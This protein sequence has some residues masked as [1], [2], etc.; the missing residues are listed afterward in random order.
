MV[1]ARWQATITDDAGNVQDAA[2]VEVRAE[3]GGA[4]LAT[5]Y[6]DRDG[7]TPISNPLT[8]GSDG[9][10]A[11]H[12]AGGAYKI[13]ASKG[14]F[15]REWRY[16]PIG[17]AAEQDSA[18]VGIS[19]IFD[20][21][22]T[23]A[24]PGAGF[25]RFNNATPGSATAL[26][27]DNVDA[28]GLTETTWL[29]SIDDG[30]SSSDRGILVMRSANGG[31]LVVARVT[32]SVVDGTG[33][34]KVTISV[35]AASDASAF[36]SGA[37]FSLIF[38]RAGIDGADGEVTSTGTFAA[39]DLAA[40]TDTGGDE[41]KSSGLSAATAANVQ[42]A[43]ANKVITADLIETAS[44]FVSLTDGANVALDWDS[45]INFSLVMAGDRVL[46]APSNAQVGTWRTIKV[47]SDSGSSRTLT[48]AA[49]YRGAGN[50]P[51]SGIT[52]VQEYLIT[53]FAV[54]SS[55]CIVGILDANNA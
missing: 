43:A 24:D 23:D 39:N 22:T 19:W 20:P 46:D 41:I 18:P 16:V 48:F 13:T 42:A 40:F 29:D 14:A 6:S 25:F 53:L 1:L 30:G 44:N 37:R 21:T 31:A 28:D 8:T 38:N 32:G 47:N 5:I 9:F 55:V 36:V 45:G 27:L 33:Y 12:V 15:S 50:T 7:T 49:G 26:Y 4:P 52:N 34:R 35:L 51:L 54:T 3:T 2:S 10:A 11:F 17:L